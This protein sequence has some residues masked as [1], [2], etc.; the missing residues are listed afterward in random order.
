[1]AMVGD[2]PVRKPS[3]HPD[4]FRTELSSPIGDSKLI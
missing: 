4:D 1:M 3:T 2:G